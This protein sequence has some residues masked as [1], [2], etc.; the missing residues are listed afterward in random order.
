LQRIGTLGWY[1]SEARA[2]NN[3]GDVT[4]YL[5]T[6]DSTGPRHTFLLRDGVLI[7]IAPDL[8]DHAP[9][10]MNSRGDIAGSIGDRE[11]YFVFIDNVFSR[12]VPDAYVPGSPVDINFGRQVAGD[13]HF[14]TNGRLRAY[15]WENGVAHPLPLG[16][17]VAHGA[18]SINNAGDVVGYGFLDSEPDTRVPFLYRDGKIKSLG[19]IPGYNDSRAEAISESGIILINASAGYPDFHSRAFRYT[20]GVRE[21]L[22]TL[23]GISSSGADIN[24]AGHVVGGSE[25]ANGERHAF[26]HDGMAM[27]DLGTLG[28]P[29]S[30][31]VDITNNG[32][33]CGDYT[34]ADDVVRPFIYLA[35]EKSTF[36]LNSLVASAD[37]LKPHVRLHRCTQLNEFGQILASGFDSRVNRWRSYVVMPVDTT[38]PSINA[39]LTGIQGS[40]GWFTSNVDLAWIVTDPEAPIGS[41]SGC[42]KSSVTADTTGRRFVCEAASMGGHATK[43]VT[44]KRDSAKPRVNISIPAAGAVYSRNQIVV[45]R[46]RC[47][48]ATSEID[49]CTGPVAS[50]A[51][52]DTSRPARHKTFTVK[53]IDKAGLAR[54]VTV[55]Y[56]IK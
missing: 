10:A 14:E 18:S 1:G 42:R 2:I 43:G 7:D 12:L 11:S 26:L 36:D 33:A 21:D 23:G 47:A 24:H 48:D 8:Y 17:F 15:I 30:F 20:N 29:D 51:A 19:S 56:S 3:H 35:G 55:T 31:A 5:Y 9:H 46:Y 45:T 4:G 28:G 32:Q 34:G 25:R 50:G 52:L 27:I 40:N 49:R 16:P 54:S 39:R 38:K 37:P 44:I 53:A 6:S 22:G 13:G 41:K